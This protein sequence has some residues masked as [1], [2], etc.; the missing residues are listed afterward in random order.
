MG[1][2]SS[3]DKEKDKV[4]SKKFEL[5]GEELDIRKNRKKIG[6]VEIAKEIIEEEKIVDVP[7]THEEVVIERRAV[8]HERSDSHIEPEESIHIPVSRETVD[9]DKHTVVTGEVLA[10]KK[11]VEDTERVSEVLKRE[12][13]RVRKDG[14]PNI[15]S[16]IREG[17]SH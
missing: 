17:H 4:D 13:A 11:E 8:D 16:D 9:V 15:V 14:E 5:R 7:L 6:D 1:W 10:H 2:F 12:E 3:K